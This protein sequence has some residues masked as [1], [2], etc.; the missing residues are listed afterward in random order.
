[1]QM[2]P[3]VGYRERH[4]FSRIISLQSSLL[5]CRFTIV[6]LEFT[7]CRTQFNNFMTKFGS[8]D[9][10][11][12]LRDVFARY[13][14]SKSSKN[15]NLQAGQALILQRCLHF[16]T[17]FVNPFELGC[18]DMIATVE[19]VSAFFFGFLL[20]LAAFCSSLF[21][22]CSICPDSTSMQ[23]KLSL[24]EFE[25]AVR[26]KAARQSAAMAFDPK[27]SLLVAKL[28]R[29]VHDAE[30]TLDD[31][32]LLAN[33]A[34]TAKT[35]EGAANISMGGSSAAAESSSTETSSSASSAGE[36]DDSAGDLPPPVNIAELLS[37]K[38]AG[39]VQP[40]STFFGSLFS[41]S[42]NQPI[43]CAA[44]Q[45]SNRGSVAVSGSSKQDYSGPL[46]VLREHRA[47]SASP[48]QQ[49]ADCSFQYHFAR[50][51]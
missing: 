34:A 43:R 10:P 23:L 18:A 28:R 15:D 48:D 25:L 20:F 51:L 30:V 19:K 8:S 37:S 39:D 36:E 26:E 2:R 42:G 24:S 21:L 33:T 6:F 29:H 47:A 46:Q 41:C 44:V 11:P 45:C 22:L 9:E 12:P 17:T 16:S 35:T 49:Q 38:A 32:D 7:E 5:S 4:V 40:V 50:Q 1:M 13:I 3:G 27:L 31:L 14:L